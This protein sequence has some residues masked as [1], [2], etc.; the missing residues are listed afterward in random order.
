MRTYFLSLM[1]TV[2]QNK[3]ECL[4]MFLSKQEPTQ[5]EQHMVP[6]FSTRPYSQTL[7]NLEKILLGKTR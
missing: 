2:R 3:L 5:V 6:H 1:L 7:D 4:T